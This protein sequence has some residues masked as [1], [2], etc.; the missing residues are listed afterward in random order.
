MKQKEER[1]DLDLQEATNPWQYLIDYLTDAF[2]KDLTQSVL[3]SLC[4]DED[5]YITYNTD[6]ARQTIIDTLKEETQN[7]IKALEE[8]RD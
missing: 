7:F 3:L 2:E 4:R 6:K 1:A 5:I 8:K